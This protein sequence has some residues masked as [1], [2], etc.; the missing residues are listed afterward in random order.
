M[1]HAL[2]P[3]YIPRTLN[4]EPAQIGCGDNKDDPFYFAGQY[5]KLRKPKLTQL[6]GIERTWRK[7]EK[8][9]PG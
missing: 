5:G 9:V 3:I 1:S 6:K 7:K 2:V 4:T 8:E